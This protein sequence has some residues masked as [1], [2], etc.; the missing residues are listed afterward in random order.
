MNTFKV[1]WII[2]AA[3]LG[4]AASAVQA[5][6]VCYVD[7]DALGG[8]DGASWATAYRFLQDA[9]ASLGD[10]Q[11]GV[12]EVRV[13]GGVYLPDRYDGV[14]DGTGS[15]QASFELTGDVVLRGGYLGLAAGPGES[16]DQRDPLGHPSILSGDLAGD[17]GPDFAG[18][19]ENSYHVVA[20]GDGAV[21]PTLA[22]FTVAAGN[23]D[24]STPYDHGGG[25]YNLAG[26]PLFSGCTFTGNAAGEGGAMFNAPTS[27]ATVVRC[28]FDGNTAAGRGG[29]MR[30]SASD[31]T[32][33]GCLFVGNTAIEGGGMHN[34]GPNR[35]VVLG[36]VFEGN[37]AGSRGGAMF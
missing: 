28:T 1:R 4:A 31:P 17:D 37:V 16:P 7:D 34:T 32:V 2:A 14:P 19:L 30:N 26:D 3:S 36:C 10:P 35:P 8:G 9:L 13:A 11:G 25:V 27:R 29:A 6:S 5:D 33:A 21:A 24:G 12:T 22:G 18:N 15:R 23:A 20:V